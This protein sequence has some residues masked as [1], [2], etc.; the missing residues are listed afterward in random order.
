[1]QKCLLLTGA[2]ALLASCIPLKTN[3]HVPQLNYC[4][5]PTS[6]CYDSCYIPITDITPILK[7][8]TGLLKYFSYQDVLLA[9]A[10]GS[11]FLMLDLV[12]L[13]E[14]SANDED[15]T[16]YL[17]LKQQQIFNR[18]LLASIELAGAAAELDCESERS[19]QLAGYLDQINGTRT[20]QLTILSVV[21]GAA[22]GIGTSI[23]QK[24]KFQ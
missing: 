21:T 13:K 6:Y 12:R 10:S 16:L 11:L 15:S 4:A 8:N 9:N 17:M 5:P 14:N 20:Q 19:R 7:K 22:T 24:P 1:M 3:L 23:F 2:L 18:L